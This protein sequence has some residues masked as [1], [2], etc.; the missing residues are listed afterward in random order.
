MAKGSN[1]TSGGDTKPKPDEKGEAATTATTSSTASSKGNNGRQVPS[2]SAAPTA[3]GPPRITLTGAMQ[4]NLST[5]CARAL[6]AKSAKPLLNDT[7]APHVMDQVPGY[8]FSGVMPGPL[9]AAAVVKRALTLDRWTAAFLERNPRATV[10]HLACGLDS[11]CLR[12]RWGGGGG[13]GG[14]GANANTAD[15]PGTAA[16]GNFADVVWVDLDLPDVVALRRQLLPSPSG[17]GCDYR[18]VAASVADEGWL[19][20]IPAD[21][22]TLILMEGL[23]IRRHRA[24]PPPAQTIQLGGGGA[25]A[26]DCVG[27][28]VLRA[29]GLIGVLRHTGAAFGWA[30][31]YP[32]YLE[33]LDERLR[34]V[35]TQGPLAMFGCAAESELMPLPVRWGLRGLGY[36][37]FLYAAAEHVLRDLLTPGALVRF[38]F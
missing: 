1:K 14:G 8:D 2:A 32:R 37:P 5:L 4:T 29:Q 34:L 27:S 12:L 9:A 25:L 28:V 6:D 36:V 31:D 16:K 24:I 21:R 10:L 17:P 22:P 30:L 20:D 23:T 35:E 13:G 33:L 3:A 18:L 38:E 15:K 7:W 11:R 19:A 26:F